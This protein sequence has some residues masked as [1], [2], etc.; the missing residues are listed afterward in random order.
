[1]AAQVIRDQVKMDDILA[2]YGYRPRHGFLCCPFHGEKAP[3]LKIYPDTG[4]WHCF[5]C[6]RGG[7]VIDFVMEHENCNFQTAVRAIDSALHLGL[8]DLKEDPFDAERNRDFQLSLDQ[9]VES[10]YSCCKV[11]ELMINNQLIAD[12]K[13]YKTIRDKDVKDKT[14][15][16]WTF[17]HTFSDE[18]EY[19]EYRLDKIKEFREEVAAWRRKARRVKI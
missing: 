15:D 13:K 14:V 8:M 16:D 3:S 6:G 9:F 18:T 2:L 17:L 4:G 10:I 5:G 1:M 11:Q 12:M 7:S 19:N